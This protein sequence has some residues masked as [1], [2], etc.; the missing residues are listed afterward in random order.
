MTNNSC[1][2]TTTPIITISARDSGLEYNLIGLTLIFDTIDGDYATSFDIQCYLNGTLIRTINYT[3]DKVVCEM[4]TGIDNIDEIRIVFKS[5]N[6]PYRRLRLES[7]FL[8]LIKNYTSQD[9]IEAKQKWSIDLLSREIT[10]N[11]FQVT[12]DNRMS[13]YNADNPEGNNRYIQEQ[14][15]IEISYY[16]E[17]SGGIYEKINGGT[18]Y[19]TG[20]PKT[21]EYEATFEAKGILYF[22][23]DTYKKGVYNANGQTFY[24]LL[25]SLFNE[26]GITQYSID[27]SLQNWSTTIPLK[28]LP[29]KELIQLICNATNTICIEDRENY[30]R[31][32]PKDSTVKNYYL[33]LNNQKEFPVVETGAKL[34]DVNVTYYHAIVGSTLEE[35]FNGN[36]KITTRTKLQIE[37]SSAPATECI[38]TITN[39]TINSANYYAYYC[40]LDVSVTNSSN[41]VGIVIKGKKIELNKST[42][43]LSVNLNGENCDIDNPLIDSESNALLVANQFKEYLINRN[44]YTSE[45]RGEPIWDVGDVIELETQ[46][47][48]RINSAITSNEVTFDGGLSGKTTFRSM[49]G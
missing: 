10:D 31:I 37:Y 19:L 14:Q 41:D 3:N 38:A 17:T 7:I 11:N 12:I 26:A 43:T 35:V 22:L 40:E 1:N 2:F 13:R 33:D 36:F 28:L 9:I 4:T 47:T 27:N 39:G 32:I 6:K 5:M 24:S 15:P 16:Y 48:E 8:G 49:G 29:I 30:I 18:L 20:Q 25:T 45:N 42:Y 21:E 23:N 46:F 44:V 34:K